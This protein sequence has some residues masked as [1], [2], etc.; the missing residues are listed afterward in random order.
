MNTIQKYKRMINNILKEKNIKIKIDNIYN[1]YLIFYDEN[2]N[3]YKF[4]FADKKIEALNVHTIN[5]EI[6]KVKD[7]I[8]NEKQNVIIYDENKNDITN[9]F[10]FNT[11][12]TFEEYISTTVDGEITALKEAKNIYIE[13][14]HY[15]YDN[16]L[17]PTACGITNKFN[18]YEKTQ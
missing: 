8:V 11:P 6:E 9:E 3:Y 5:I 14:Y 7:M 16:I 4:Y 12:K 18:I 2:E 13:Y 17:N 15:T 1:D 10:I